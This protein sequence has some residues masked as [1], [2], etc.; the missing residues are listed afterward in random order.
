MVKEQSIFAKF[1]TDKEGKP[2]IKC[3]HPQLLERL[4]RMMNLKSFDVLEHVPGSAEFR[5]IETV[6]ID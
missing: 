5:Y 4:A 1:G 3:G 6:M 2:D